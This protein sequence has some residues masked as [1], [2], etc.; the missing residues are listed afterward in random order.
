M[1]LVH[2]E[3]SSPTDTLPQSGSG[4]LHVLDCPCMSH[5][6]DVFGV[7]ACWSSG[8]INGDHHPVRKLLQG[9]KATSHNICFLSRSLLPF[10]L[11]PGLGSL[12]SMISGPIR[13][14][15]IV[16]RPCRALRGA[17]HCV[18]RLGSMTASSLGRLNDCT[19]VPIISNVSR[20]TKTQS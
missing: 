6:V 13:G 14:N 16:A 19:A 8:A 4:P 11:P 17:L 12:W 7:L 10:H 3:L 1:S 9:C 18:F 5:H 20:P 15:F 2:V